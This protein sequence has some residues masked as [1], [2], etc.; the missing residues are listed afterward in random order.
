MGFKNGAYAKIWEV[1]PVSD[2]RTDVR[3]SVS[4]KNKKT[5]TYEQDFSGFV[6]FC[7]NAAKEVSKLG[8]GVTIKLGD[9]DVSSRFDKEAN[10]RYTSFKCFSFEEDHGGGR[11]S[12]P[13][14]TVDDGEV[15]VTGQDLPF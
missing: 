8:E 5:N 12:A 7:G 13:K 15:E 1:K 2:S 10:K 9:C 4:R 3:L 6:S 14:R 11:S